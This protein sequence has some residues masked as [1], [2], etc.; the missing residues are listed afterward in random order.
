M[1][2]HQAYIREVKKG[3]SHGPKP[4]NT[5]NAGFSSFSNQPPPPVPYSGPPFPPRPTPNVTPPTKRQYEAE[6]T[7]ERQDHKSKRQ[8]ISIANHAE[9]IDV[10]DN[11]DDDL[12]KKPKSMVVP[13]AHNSR[14]ENPTME[15]LKT[16]VLNTEY[17]GSISEFTRVENRMG[18]KEYAKYRAVKQPI[19]AASTQ[20]HSE[21]GYRVTARSGQAAKAAETT[22]HHW[23]SKVLSQS[24]SRDAFRDVNGQ[25]RGSSPSE[26]ELAIEQPSD[27]YTSVRSVI[28]PE[29]VTSKATTIS[30]S[31]ED[32]NEMEFEKDIPKTK[33]TNVPKSLSKP[34]SRR[35]AKKPDHSD[36]ILNV[37][38]VISNS[39]RHFN[40][41]SE[42]IY[43]SRDDQH[44]VF[45]LSIQDDDGFT[46][47]GL[48]VPARAIHTVIWDAESP[49]VHLK[50]HKTFD[51]PNTAIDIEFMSADDCS[52]FVAI[53]E[54]RGN[55][56]IKES[57]R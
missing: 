6:S 53:M 15:R 33:F 27:H 46:K 1:D 7:N 8:C 51:N 24:K 28:S 13:N 26:D 47:M 9:V 3:N 54:D 23:P 29:K 30:D 19:V 52:Q 11:S 38:S 56:Q 10:S 40:R 48:V 50:C 36:C 4:R 25:K 35:Q 21:V 32:Y 57:D 12:A 22:S 55:A 39:F 14:R 37:T 5:L 16:A 41:P 43:E 49:I 31:Q 18:S 17:P 44:D 20:N 42:M 2:V 34:T 45:V